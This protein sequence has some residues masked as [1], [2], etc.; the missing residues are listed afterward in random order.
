M[1]RRKPRGDRPVT[2]PSA[3]ELR[4]GVTAYFSEEDIGL[5]R[6]SSTGRRYTAP[7]VDSE[8]L[9]GA[10]AGIDWRGDFVRNVASAEHHARLVYRKSGLPTGDSRWMKSPDGK[11]S[12]AVEH[13]AFSDLR[14]AGWEGPLAEWNLAA[15]FGYSP[16]S[17]VGAAAGLLSAA[18][19]VRAALLMAES[20]VRQVTEGGQ[21]GSPA[22]LPLL[23]AISEVAIKAAD[24]ERAYELLNFYAFP[25]RRDPARRTAAALIDHAVGV[26]TAKYNTVAWWIDAYRDV[27]EAACPRGAE[28]KRP[29]AYKD[30]IRMLRKAHADVRSGKRKASGKKPIEKALPDDGAIRRALRGAAAADL[31]QLPAHLWQPSRKLP[32]NRSHPKALA[33][34]RR[35]RR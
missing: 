30:I 6:I 16:A 35:Q 8:A 13:E 20:Q 1:P 28:D 32:A 21:I 9:I 17:P 11:W 7:F 27:I 34:T 26:T 18:F 29:V 23:S 19:E 24:F 15:A 14:Q 33:A 31:I 25:Y 5:F 12:P 4:P 2:P 10:F 22:A 3:V